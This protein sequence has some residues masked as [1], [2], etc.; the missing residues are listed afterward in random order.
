MCIATNCLIYQRPVHEA[1][2]SVNHRECQVVDCL[3]PVCSDIDARHGQV[4]RAVEEEKL[5]M[6][7][8]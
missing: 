8:E 3:G 6:M 5:K 4:V 7:N 2:C 1:G